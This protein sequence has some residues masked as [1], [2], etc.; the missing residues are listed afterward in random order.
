MNY[1]L[2]IGFQI[3]RNVFNCLPFIYKVFSF[4]VLDNQSWV[5]MKMNIPLKEQNSSKHRFSGRTLHML[6]NLSRS[7][8]ILLNVNDFF[9]IVN[10]LF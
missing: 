8:K 9:A 10:T 7:Y 2:I 6:D 4:T 5:A 1:R 3:N